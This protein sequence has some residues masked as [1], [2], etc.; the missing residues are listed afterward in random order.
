MIDVP[1]GI[2]TVAAD[3]RAFSEFLAR[4]VAKL[5]RFNVHANI[6]DVLVHMEQL[7]PPES[8][9]KILVDIYFQVFEGPLRVLHPI[10]K[11]HFRAFLKGQ[12]IP[13]QRKTCLPILLAVV[14]IVST[15]AAY[16]QCDDSKLHGQEDGVG[17]YHLLRNYLALLTEREWKELPPLQV[18]VLTLKAHKSSPLD[19][20]KTWQ[21]SGEIVRRAMGAGIHCISTN[22]ANIYESEIKRRLWL[23]ILEMDLAFAIACNMPANCPPWDLDPPLSVNDGRIYPLMQYTPASSDLG[24]WTDGLCQHVL[25]QSFNDRRAAYA[26]V[27]SGKLAPYQT[28][29]QHTRHLEQV[30]YDLP[31]VFRLVSMSDRDPNSP[32]RLIARMELDFLLRRPL[33]A[34]YARYGA[35]MPAGDEFK[36][37]RIPWIQGCSYSLCF[38]DLFDPKYPSLDLPVPEGLWDFF[39]NAYRWEV[40]QY[41][42]SNCL[43]LQRLKLLD[44]DGVDRA[45]RTFQGHTLRDTVKIKGWTIESITKSLEDTIDPMKRRLGRYGSDFGEVVRWVVI[46][47]A[48]RASPSFSHYHAIKNE[49]QE[50]VSTLRAQHSQ[51]NACLQK[52]TA[53]Q[54]AR[55]TAPSDADWLKS[56]LLGDENEDADNHDT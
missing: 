7:L 54:T 51:F 23:T 4:P 18:A 30:V 26:L 19:A 17:A 32:Y 55:R 40:H 53:P 36:E 8:D 6:E 25:A 44:K 13:G 29:L 12:L 45:S 38:Q 49:L 15:L 52:R 46:I 42:L 9:C 47:G 31:R 16:F 41:L 22:S 20:M 5:E 3:V 34:C 33:L 39:Y 1:A 14:S 43:E 10:S 48:L 50:L 2:H 56:L 37:A 11:T 21:W 27:S 24:E 35:E 28:V